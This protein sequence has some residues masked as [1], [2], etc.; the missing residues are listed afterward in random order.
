MSRLDYLTI[1]IVAL[2]IAALIYLVYRYVNLPHSA[3]NN[4]PNTE[5]VQPDTTRSV[6]DNTAGFP[7]EDTTSNNQPGPSTAVK[8]ETTPEKITVKPEVKKP[9][10]VPVKPIET[11]T[12]SESASA[13]SG[14]YMVIA[15]SF[16]QKSGAQK[17]LQQIKKLG[18]NNVQIGFF[19]RG[20]Y[21]VV[22]VDRFDQ[23]SDAQALVKTLKGKG[24]DAMIRVK[25]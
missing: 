6:T 19:N 7:D 11:N 14:R 18:Y 9:V 23:S 1:G 8:P 21:A 15:G 25:K 2:C 24:F 13:A 10:P 20:T 12:A 17:R 3:E 4:Q 16:E 22:V 5:V